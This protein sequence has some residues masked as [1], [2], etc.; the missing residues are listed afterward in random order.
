MRWPRFVGL[1]SLAV[2]AGRDN[3]SRHLVAVS[4][5]T[6]SK[7]SVMFA[8]ADPISI[9]DKVSGS[10]ASISLK[11]GFNCFRFRA[12]VDGR[13]VDVIDSAADFPDT[14]ARPSGNGTPILFPFPNR[15]AGGRFQW[16]GK[17][18]Q[19]PLAGN[20]P[21]AIHGFAHTV[22]W[23]V[24]ARTEDTVTAEFQLSRD[25]PAMVKSWPADC[26]IQLRYGVLGATLR[27]DITISNPDDR[28]L[29]WG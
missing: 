6:L 8:P 3:P 16:D 4:P 13:V 27:M 2:E 5:Q 15:I 10:Q 25:N 14:G 11:H 24:I 1:R 21:N 12:V 26:R 19:I 17:D 23:R 22:P 9:V 7:V 28:P 18:Y 20:A 29:P